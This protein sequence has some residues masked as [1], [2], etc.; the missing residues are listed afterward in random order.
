MQL[1]AAKETKPSKDSL[2]HAYVEQEV[3]LMRILKHPNIV[4]FEEAFKRPDKSWVIVMEYCEAGD[5]FTQL[6][7]LCEEG[8]VGAAQPF[9][10]SG[11]YRL[12]S[13]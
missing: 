6:S 2:T 7:D 12:T 4:A 9:S 5:L 11:S 8:Y 3:W 13:G 10:Y 1:F